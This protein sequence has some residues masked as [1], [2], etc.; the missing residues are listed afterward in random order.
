MTVKELIERLSQYREDLRVVVETGSHGNYISVDTTTLA[1][2]YH[3]FGEGTKDE[4]FAVIRLAPE[5]KW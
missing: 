4:L 2:N 3:A 1:Q 5:L